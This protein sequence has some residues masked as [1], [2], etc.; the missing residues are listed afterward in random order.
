MGTDSNIVRDGGNNCLAHTRLIA[1]M[2]AASD[3]AAT[4]YRQ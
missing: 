3:V 2:P 1:R 4:D